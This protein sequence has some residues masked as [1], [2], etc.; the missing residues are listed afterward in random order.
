MWTELTASRI[1]FWIHV[2][3]LVV[4]LAGCSQ[5]MAQSTLG[6]PTGVNR[7]LANEP[8]RPTLNSRVE[9]PRPT[10]RDKFIPSPDFE[11]PQTLCWSGDS[12]LEC[13][14]RKDI[15]PIE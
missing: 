5:S 8:L 13:I 14:R 7:T 15:T 12:G 1:R 9:R 6:G 11:R 3:L 2:I 10:L 4:V